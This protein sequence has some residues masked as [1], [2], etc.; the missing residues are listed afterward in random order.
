MGE[1]GRNKGVKSKCFPFFW[2]IKR[3]GGTFSGFG[4]GGQELFR[5]TNPQKGPFFFIQSHVL[6]LFLEVSE[7]W[8]VYEVPKKPKGPE[9]P[10]EPE[11]VPLFQ[12][13]L[14]CN[15]SRKDFPLPAEPQ[16]LSLL[17]FR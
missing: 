14:R 8:E 1:G 9:V 16:R 12:A 2:I 11:V 13:M 7:V 3:L 6:G 15:T 17:A 10:K 4:V 5:K